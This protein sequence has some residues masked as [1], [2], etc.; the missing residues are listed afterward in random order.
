MLINQN[1]RYEKY[2]KVN[3]ILKRYNLI[4]THLTSTKKTN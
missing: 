1:S 2:D 4:V 3:M